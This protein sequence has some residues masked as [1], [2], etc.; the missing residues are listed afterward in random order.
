MYSMVAP[1]LYHLWWPQRETC[2]IGLGHWIWK[3][4][5]Y[6]SAGELFGLCPYSNTTFSQFSQAVLESLLGSLELFSLFPCLMCLMSTLACTRRKNKGRSF[7]SNRSSIPTIFQCLANYLCLG[8]EWQRGRELPG[9]RVHGLLIHT[10]YM[11]AS[12]HTSGRDGKGV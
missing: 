5:S 9:Y 2:K 8:V 3:A 7:H 6:V 4:S 10:T 11:C 1:S 12:V